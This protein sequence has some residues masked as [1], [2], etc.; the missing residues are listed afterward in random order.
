MLHSSLTISLGFVHFA[1]IFAAVAGTIFFI[2][3]Y[4]VGGQSGRADRSTSLA[5]LNLRRMRE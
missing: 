1:A 5:T 4:R 3:R 2:V